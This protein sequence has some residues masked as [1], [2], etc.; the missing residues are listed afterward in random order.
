MRLK[1][2]SWG[3]SHSSHSSHDAN[4]TASPMINFPANKIT[5]L[6]LLPS[7]CATYDV[8]GMD[9]ESGK[10]QVICTSWLFLHQLPCMRCRP[11]HVSLFSSYSSGRLLQAILDQIVVCVISTPI[12][13]CLT[14]ILSDRCL[15]DK[16]NLPTSCIPCMKHQCNLVFVA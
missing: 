11:M 14:P 10:R 4:L 2:S 8:D 16:R 7:C 6:E 12:E 15:Q 9:Q 1:L 3:S 5:D 13:T